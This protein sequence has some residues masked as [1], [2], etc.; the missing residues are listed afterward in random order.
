MRKLIHIITVILVLSVLSIINCGGASKKSDN[1]P[2]SYLAEDFGSNHLVRSSDIRIF[3]GESLFEYINGGAELYHLY[4][5]TD[6]ATADYKVGS[7]ELVADIYRFENPD[8]A[9]G[10]YSSF[11]PSAA[12]IVEMGVEG[13]LTGNSLDFVKG[14]YLIRVIGYDDSEESSAA[15]KTLAQNINAAI[16]RQTGLPAIYNF[17][18]D[19]NVLSQSEVVFAESYLGRIYLTDVYTRQYQFDEETITLFVSDDISGDKFL[20]WSEDESE[21]KIMRFAQDKSSASELLSFSYN[22][23]YYDMV[24]VAHYHGKLVGIVNYNDHLS[25][26]LESWLTLLE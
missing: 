23:K 16:V 5:F 15:I 12:E 25:T 8:F 19:D 6:V 11:R 26:Y 21:R 14:E 3:A 4:H 20:K 2:S 22:D 1:S 9:F 24:A 17:F 10:L 7:I 13:F 18:P